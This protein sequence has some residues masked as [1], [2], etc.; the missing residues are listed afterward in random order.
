MNNIKDV[1]KFFVENGF[2]HDVYFET[3]DKSREGVRL[4]LDYELDNDQGFTHSQV[5]YLMFQ[6]AHTD[7]VDLGRNGD[8]DSM[9]VLLRSINGANKR[10]IDWDGT[11]EITNAVAAAELR[12][13]KNTT[14]YTAYFIVRYPFK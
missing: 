8:V 11:Y 12:P 14:E 2:G 13:K 1:E 3:E 5:C 4:R 7:L 9:D 10:G 6:Q